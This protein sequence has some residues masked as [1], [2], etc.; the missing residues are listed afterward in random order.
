M[1]DERAFRQ[2]CGAAGVEDDQPGLGIDAVVWKGRGCA[3]ECRFIIGTQFHPRDTAGIHKVQ[4][5]GF[6]GAEN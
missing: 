4:G 3:G 2:A 1:T 5:L 6:A